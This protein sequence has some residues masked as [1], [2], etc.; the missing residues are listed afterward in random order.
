M[1]T[2]AFIESN[3]TGTGE[4]IIQM[5]LDSGN[6]V[7]FFTCKPDKYAFLNKFELNPAFQLVC[8][9]TSCFE[10]LRCFLHVAH[11]LMLVMSSSEI[12]VEISA[13][14]A[15]HF[16]LFGPPPEAVRLC[17]DKYALGK[18]LKSRG[19]EYP[20]T[21]SYPDWYALQ[22][23]K[24]FPVVLKPRSG[25]GSQQVF[26]AFNTTEI[27]EKLESFGEVNPHDFLVQEYVSG[28][29]YSAEVLCLNGEIQVMAIVA[30]YL[31]EE[32]Y[33]LEVGH[34]CPAQVNDNVK[35]IMEREVIKLIKS[36]GFD[37]GFCHVEFRLTGAEQV[38]VIEINPRMAG[39]MIPL[40]LNY[41]MDTDL[42]ALTY[43]LFSR[44]IVSM[45]NFKKATGK[46]A[47]IRFLVANH[48]GKFKALHGLEAVEN[49][50]GVQSCGYM[51]KLGDD[52]TLSGSYKDR[53]AYV[54]VGAD[55]ES[56]CMLVL[57]N[58][59]NKLSAEVV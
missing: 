42:I 25:T 44:D 16:G 43:Q 13:R 9:D 15:E 26:L 14:L 5:A 51:A 46:Q 45:P 37:N 59:M 54:I 33:F 30:K 40:A 52:I 18:K 48:N 49:L 24:I 27:E 41:I 32:P 28:P 56:E 10:I 29:E 22:S 17:R 39:G 7:Q 8:C 57:N 53:L 55:S 11:N 31:G 19:V 20:N 23:E 21:E 38:V 47:G 34:H 4:R 35:Q 3:T 2:V 50:D 1:N 12:Y 6:T 36:V 58:A